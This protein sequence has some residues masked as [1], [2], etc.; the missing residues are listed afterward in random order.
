[1]SKLRFLSEFQA[2]N[3]TQQTNNPKDVTRIQLL[4]EEASFSCFDRKQVKVADATVDQSIALTDSNSEYLLIYTDQ[5]IT[6]KLDGSADT[7]TLKPK[8]AGIKTLVY[9]E[10][11]DSTSLLV[12]NA[13]GSQA[14]L[15]ILS[16]KL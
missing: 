14:N 10:R 8:S 7:R 13:S 9:F 6:I 4:T 12:S 15:D 16:V 3:D 11:G 1:M 2:Y 5:E